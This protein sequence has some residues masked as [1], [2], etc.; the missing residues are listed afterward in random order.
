MTG[1]SATADSLEMDLAF[2]TETEF[3]NI[4]LF[5]LDLVTQLGLEFDDAAQALVA[6]QQTIELQLAMQS[7]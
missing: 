4:V 1:L 5:K 3:R 6:V 7:D 2:T